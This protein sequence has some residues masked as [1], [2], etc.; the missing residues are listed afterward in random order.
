M[1]C[2]QNLGAEDGVREWKR[3]RLGSFTYL[4]RVCERD[5]A[6]V[7]YVF[8]LIVVG[9]ED[10]IGFSWLL[11]WYLPHAADIVAGGCR[12]CPILCLWIDFIFHRRTVVV[13]SG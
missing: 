6:G 12:Y 5:F 8:L 11:F 2:I 4:L 13:R 9:E 7:S 3:S 1:A 10:P